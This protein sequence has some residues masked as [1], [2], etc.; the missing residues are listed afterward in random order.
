[1]AMQE[2][3]SMTKDNLFAASQMMPVVSDKL[4]VASGEGVLERGALLDNAG[5]LVT[6]EAV[7][8]AVLA[9][10]VDATNASVEAPVYLTGEFNK[11]ALKVADGADISTFIQGA[12]GN[13]I[14]IKDCIQ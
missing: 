8:Y 12:R 2:S 3:Y 9:A 13:S 4:T 5:K 10:P 6:G 11:N 1:M 14:F 7:V